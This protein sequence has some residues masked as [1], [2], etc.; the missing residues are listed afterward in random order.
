VTDWT[1]CPECGAPAAILDRPVLASTGGAVEHAR[2]CCAA[3]HRF[4]MPTE[5]LATTAA[6]VGLEAPPLEEP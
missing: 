6:E 3:G 1:H 5:S 2:V 4:L